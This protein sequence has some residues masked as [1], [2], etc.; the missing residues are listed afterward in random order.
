MGGG[1]EGGIWRKES[2]GF[3]VMGRDEGSRGM[4]YIWIEGVV[5]GIGVEKE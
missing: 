2:Q 5:Y 3:Y 4:Y 1:E